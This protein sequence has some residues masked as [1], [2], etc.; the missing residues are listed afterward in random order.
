MFLTERREGGRGNKNNKIGLKISLVDSR[1]RSPCG[2]KTNLFL[3]SSF[4]LLVTLSLPLTLSLSH[5]LTPS[6]S[7]DRQNVRSVRLA[8]NISPQTHKNIEESI[9]CV[10][11]SRTSTLQTVRCDTAAPPCEIFLQISYYCKIS[12]ELQ[13]KIRGNNDMKE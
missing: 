5:S 9:W 8:L 11:T 6:N 7:T 10:D 3:P 13:R 4:V 2:V 12:L 1:E